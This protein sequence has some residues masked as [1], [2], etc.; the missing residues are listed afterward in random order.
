MRRKLLVGCL[1]AWCATSSPRKAFAEECT[2]VEA[3]TPG[4][5]QLRVYFTKF[6]TEDRTDGKYKKCRIVAKATAATQT[7]HVTQFRRDA[8]VVV[9]RANWPTK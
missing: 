9:L 7:Y 1:I 3:K 4:E 6:A 2:L 8:N 5:A